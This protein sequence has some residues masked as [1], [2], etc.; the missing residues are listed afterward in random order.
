MLSKGAESLSNAELIA[1]L[2]GTGTKKVN[3]LE[4]A[5]N[6][7]S[8]KGGKLKEIAG[9]KPD[10]MSDL[11]GIGHNKYAAI[12]AAFELGKRC[13]LED[14]GIQKVAVT[15]ASMIYRTM[16]PFLKGID[17]EEFWI[18][19]LNKANY[20]IHKEMMSSGGSDATIVDTKLVIKE[21]LDRHACGMIMVHNHPSGNPRPGTCDIKQTEMMKKAA[22]T[23][24][25][26]LVDHIIICDDCFFSF[27]DEK[28]TMV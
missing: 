19:F 6:L 13:W 22:N 11:E 1:I 5:N 14:S 23:F 15:D 16:I 7:L 17:H 10:Q 12:A 4:V 25:I 24:D 18:V 21:A 20:I 28:V 8:R 9:M 27:A 26:S 3:V 2:I